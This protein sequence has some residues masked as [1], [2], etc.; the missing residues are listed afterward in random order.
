MTSFD[1]G[2][3]LLPCRVAFFEDTKQIDP[4]IIKVDENLDTNDI[5][6]NI[7]RNVTDTLYMVIRSP[8]NDCSSANK[9]S[10]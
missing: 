7:K 8:F 4:Q 9:Q 6:D 10:Q 2:K 1:C 3:K 5:T